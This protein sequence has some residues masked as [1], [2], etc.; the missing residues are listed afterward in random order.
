MSSCSPSTPTLRSEELQLKAEGDEEL[1]SSCFATPL[2]SPPPSRP[3]SHIFL[4]ES[5]FELTSSVP[6]ESGYNGSADDGR[7][8]SSE[9]TDCKELQQ[10]CCGGSSSTSDN[11][12]D[13]SK[14]EDSHIK[15]ISSLPLC[16]LNSFNDSGISVSESAMG[17]PLNTPGADCRCAPVFLET[18]G[19]STAASMEASLP[20]LDPLPDDEDCV[21]PRM[22]ADM[23]L[24]QCVH[25][26]TWSDAIEE[27][28]QA[29]EEEEEEEEDDDL[30]ID[31]S[32]HSVSSYTPL[33][34]TW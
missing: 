24:S 21:A 13:G 26:A 31:D 9:Q 4:V 14:E 33:Q 2:S 25:M 11:E 8:T 17:T 18:L 16:F 20:L 10:Q 30:E 7:S 29:D 28:Q 15:M 19:S 22:T 1:S 27:E 6:S 34:Y 32:M 3:A 12:D 23:E 5:E